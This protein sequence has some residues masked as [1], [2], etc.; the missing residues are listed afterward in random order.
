MKR[1][2]LSSVILVF[3]IL[4]SLST[5]QS[6]EQQQRRFSRVRSS[7]SEK[8]ETVK[9]LFSSANVQFPPTQ[10]F[11]RIFKFEQ[12]LELWAAAAPEDTF[13]LI[14]KYKFCTSSGSL[15]PKRQ[16]GDYQIPEGFYHIDRFNPT[17]NFY[18]SLG[19][20][21][22][23]ASDKI[24]GKKGKLGGDIFIH[25]DCVTIGCVPITDD[26][27]K[28]LFIIAVKTKSNGQQKIPVHIFPYNFNNSKTREHICNI[29]FYKDQLPFWDNLEKGYR[30]FEEKRRLPEIEVDRS[31]GC[32]MIDEIE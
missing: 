23:N 29:I 25:G 31:T 4:V 9:E 16:Q 30:F 12:Q 20:N 26:K 19:L 11:I 15:G 27:I 13:K 14:T 1:R 28:E 10:I 18:L 17:S 8:E 2:F 3:F 24:L 7:F 6:F 32:Y 22:P 21:Y 5:S